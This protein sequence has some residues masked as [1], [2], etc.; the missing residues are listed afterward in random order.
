M[1]GGLG[2]LGGGGL[3]SKYYYNLSIKSSSGPKKSPQ[4]S[5]AGV[6]YIMWP[7][8]IPKAESIIY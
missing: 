7:S 8:K 3:Q 2:G 5:K 6:I 1:G 4:N